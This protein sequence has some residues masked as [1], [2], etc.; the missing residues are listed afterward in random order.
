MKIITKT[1]KN[2]I[3]LRYIFHVDKRTGT[4]I[5]SQEYHVFYNNWNNFSNRENQNT[6]EQK[7]RDWGLYSERKKKLIKNTRRDWNG[8]EGLW[9]INNWKCTCFVLEPFL[10]VYTALFDYV[11]CYVYFYFILFSCSFSHLSFIRSKSIHIFIHKL[12]LFY[13]H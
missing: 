11:Y 13:I 12:F 9:S 10:V 3:D 4:A 5:Y 7:R 6:Y 8:K 2:T 1:R